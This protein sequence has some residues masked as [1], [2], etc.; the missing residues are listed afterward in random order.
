[1]DN[2]PFDAQDMLEGSERLKREGKMPPLPDV[3]AILAEV[4]AHGHGGMANIPNKVD[5]AILPL[6]TADKKLLKKARIKP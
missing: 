5:L 4:C 3:L 1:M 6:T 2:T